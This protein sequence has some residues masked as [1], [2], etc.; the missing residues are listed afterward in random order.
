MR[1]DYKSD[2]EIK[3]LITTTKSESKELVARVYCH[4]FDVAIVGRSKASLPPA[5]LFYAVRLVFSLSFFLFIVIQT[6]D[7]FSLD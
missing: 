7:A 6:L 3:D 4:S 2:V 5:S 1:A